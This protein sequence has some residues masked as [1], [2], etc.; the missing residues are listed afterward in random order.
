MQSWSQ[1]CLWWLQAFISYLT[2]VLS[3]RVQHCSP[4]IPRLG[5]TNNH[6]LPWSAVFEIRKKKWLSHGQP[7][8][9]FGCPSKF[10][11]VHTWNTC[12]KVTSSLQIYGCPSDNFTSILGCPATLLVVPG[13]RTT[14]ISNAVPNSGESDCTQ[15]QN[16]F[17]Q[18]FKIC[19]CCCCCCYELNCDC[20]P[21]L[22]YVDRF[23]AMMIATQAIVFV[24]LRVPSDV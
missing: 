13:A 4:T 24:F 14:K 3:F 9:N 22:Y 18:R 23:H 12:T 17:V 15:F 10:L 1:L 16:I 21:I 5:C 7:D 11:V 20:R 19:C 8:Y 6:M 2:W